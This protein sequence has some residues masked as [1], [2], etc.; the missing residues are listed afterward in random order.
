MQTPSRRPRLTWLGE[1]V[2]ERIGQRAAS[3]EPASRSSAASTLAAISP[4]R[5]LTGCRGS[6]TPSGAPRSSV[7]SDLGEERHL[8][9][10]LDAERFGLATTTAMAEDLV[11]RTQLG[12]A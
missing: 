8:A 4:N 6:T 10:Q 7:R 9:K 5:R 12:H 1:S 11:A 3:V 2:K